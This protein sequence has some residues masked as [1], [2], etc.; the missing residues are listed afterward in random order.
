MNEPQ[1]PQFTLE[2]A[3]PIAGPGVRP[4]QQP[5]QGPTPVQEEQWKEVRQHRV[6]LG[7]QNT[8]QP[9]AAT[10]SRRQIKLTQLDL[11]VMVLEQLTKL[12]P[13]ARRQVINVINRLFP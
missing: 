11:T 7:E 1:R 2:R 10:T 8:N 9:A 13:K 12:N 6:N 3:S 5:W 4:E